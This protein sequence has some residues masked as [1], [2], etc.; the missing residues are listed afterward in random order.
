MNQ[1]VSDKLFFN[2]RKIEFIAVPQ[3]GIIIMIFFENLNGDLINADYYG[4]RGIVIKNE[5]DKL[6]FE[7]SSYIRTG[8]IQ[9]KEK[10]I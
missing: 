4:T 2:C 8:K 3:Y 1:S 5:Q 7:N 6:V 9:K 10:N